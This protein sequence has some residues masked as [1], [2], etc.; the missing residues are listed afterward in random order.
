M[1]Q[2]EIRRQDEACRVAEEERIRSSRMGC[3]EF[4]ELFRPVKNHHD[5]SA[6]W[7]GCL[8]STHGVQHNFVR[9]QRAETVWTLTSHGTLISG[10][11]FADRAGYIVT[12]VPWNRNLEVIP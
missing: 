3:E 7:S 2:D 6:G 9:N 1:N 12:E 4:Y 5:D 8:F 10:Y 11:H